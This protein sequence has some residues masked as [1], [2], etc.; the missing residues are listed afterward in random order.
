[1]Q[2]KYVS[3]KDD[4]LVN[5]KLFDL[6]FQSLTAILAKTGLLASIFNKALQ[7]EA[8][9]KVLR[10]TLKLLITLTFKAQN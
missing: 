5:L 3:K 6:D 2:N 7:K 9:D 1:M 10:V 4:K 8:T